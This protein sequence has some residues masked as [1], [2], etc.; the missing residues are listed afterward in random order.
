MGT[1]H[2]YWILTGPPFASM[3]TVRYIKTHDPEYKCLNLDK[4]TDYER[5]V[6]FRFAIY[7]TE[8]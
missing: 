6:L 4:K 8:Y 1:R 5:I 2:L 3:C 7:L